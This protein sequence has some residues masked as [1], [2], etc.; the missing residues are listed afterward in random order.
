MDHVSTVPPLLSNRSPT[1][2]FLIAVNLIFF[3]ILLN[4]GGVNT[5]NLVM[6]G[7]KVNGLIADG[8]VYRLFVPMFLHANLLHLLINMMGLYQLGRILELTL[9]GKKL[10]LLYFVSGFAGNCASFAFVDAFS[11]GASGSLFGMMTCL[12]VMQKYEERLV[13][14]GVLKSSSYSLGFLLIINIAISFVV[15][16]IDAANHLGGAFAGIMLGV[17][18]VFE[19]N[20]FFNRLRSAK[21]ESFPSTLPKLKF[22]Q[23]KLFFASFIVIFCVICLSKVL[24]I[25]FPERALGHGYQ[26]AS[27]NDTK[28]REDM[29]IDQF[30][31]VLGGAK[32]EL[33][34]VPFLEMA[35]KFHQQNQFEK[36]LV[37][38]RFVGKLLK[39]K[40]ELKAP[41][42][43]TDK[44]TV[45]D[46]FQ[47]AV[48]KTPF[49]AVYLDIL[50][51]SGESLQQWNDTKMEEKCQKSEKILENMGFF[52]L[53]GEMAQ[54]LFWFDQNNP[55][56]AGKVFK[57]YTLALGESQHFTE[58]YMELLK[59]HPVY[60]WSD[61]IFYPDRVIES[62]REITF[63]S[64]YQESLDPKP[65]PRP[66][67]G[68]HPN[69]SP[70]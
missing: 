57:N 28:P 26:M 17:P 47:M 2:L 1:T 45:D 30:N 10:L 18:I 68:I 52:D 14:M 15:P 38:Y 6:F 59:I 24:V 48:Q 60:A 41:R 36:A 7:G 66:D 5:Y 20:W 33:N 54:C 49:D 37:L 13:A 39:H 51:I 21:F 64:T 70:T 44:T 22:Y 25:S 23:G 62:W 31:L 50:E 29:E 42:S 9:G 65:S 34:A 11:V 58:F 35:L 55:K 67:L 16:G 8:Q 61:L 19:Q 27:F 32:S 12:Y 40:F 69:D 3:L 53:A 46:L 43:K 56:A 4:Q 63:P